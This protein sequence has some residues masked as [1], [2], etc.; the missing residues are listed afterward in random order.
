VVN[1]SAGLASLLARARVECP[2]PQLDDDHL[3]AYLEA[4]HGD[5]LATLD[6]DRLHAG[7]LRLA[8]ACVRGDTAALA[9]F[10]RYLDEQRAPLAAVDPAA[11]FADE[12]I[13]TLRHK[14]LVADSG[15]PGRLARYGGT[16]PLGGWL[17]VVALR[18]ALELRRKDW[19]EVP[20]EDHLAV[21]AAS[22]A[23]T[24]QQELAHAEHAAMLRTALV[25]AVAQQPSR[26]RTLLRYYYLDGVGVEEL[27]RLY[28]V[29][30]STVSRWLASTREAILEETRKRMAVALA[31]S[32]SDVE[33][34]LGLTGSLEIS[35]HSLLRD[36]S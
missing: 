22:P 16:G 31:R 24:P 18:Q 2:E 5:D 33:S 6:V 11:S 12:V 15:G 26:M 14:L 1:R 17:R 20:V 3:V 29:H 21:M 27:G 35:L 34:M 9:A 13:Q 19:R 10:E 32:E 30:A 25:D 28:R 23:R 8:A 4:V 36:R 7:E